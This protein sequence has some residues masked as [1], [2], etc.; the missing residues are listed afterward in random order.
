MY[1]HLKIT[2]DIPIRSHSSQHEPW[3]AG[4]APP[5]IQERSWLGRE[6]WRMDGS[7]QQFLMLSSSFVLW[8]KK[9]R[10]GITYTIMTNSWSFSSF[11][12]LYSKL[13]QWK[14]HNRRIIFH[15]D[16]NFC[17]LFWPYFEDYKACLMVQ[18]AARFSFCYSLLRRNT[19]SVDKPSKEHHPYTM[20]TTLWPNCKGSIACSLYRGSK[21]VG[22]PRERLTVK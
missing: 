1:R 10:V 17:T 8:T 20:H 12:D 4:S 2:S 13:L 14:P 9:K 3:F 22:K 18:T 15:L 21:I 11:Q 16:F 5:V 19:R 6:V 7:S